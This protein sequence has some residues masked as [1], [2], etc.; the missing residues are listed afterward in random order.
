[1]GAVIL[2]TDAAF[3]FCGDTAKPLAWGWL[4]NSPSHFQEEIVAHSW[5]EDISQEWMELGTHLK[6]LK[7]E[8]S[9]SGRKSV[10]HSSLIFLVNSVI[11]FFFFFTIFFFFFFYGEKFYI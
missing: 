10:I 1:M 4:I 7:S 2:T 3:T 11:F 5:F 8:D 6:D 9:R